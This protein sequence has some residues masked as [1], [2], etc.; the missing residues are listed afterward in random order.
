M[1]AA[2]RLP[3]GVLA[4]LQGTGSYDIR[5]LRL[6]SLT[7]AEFAQALA[8]V[9]D[10]AGLNAAFEVLRSGDGAA[11]NV[12]GTINVANGVATFMPVKFAVPGASAVISAT[13]ELAAG[14]IDMSVT[15]TLSQPF[16]LPP[17]EVSFAGPPEELAR[18]EDKLELIARLGYSLM[19]KGVAELER[20]QRE[21]ERIAAEEERLRRRCRKLAAYYAQRDELLLRRRELKVHAEMRVVAAEK[22]RVELEAERAADLDMNRVEL[23]QRL[24]ELRVHRRV[25]KLASD[26]T[27][28]S[29]TPAARPRPVKRA[30]PP[31]QQ[32]P[33]IIVPPAQ[34]PSQWIRLPAGTARP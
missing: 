6:A 16:G 30:R 33:E 28:A 26:Q 5:D 1:R 9:K 21:Q 23:R 10:A 31:E 15:L 18:A 34:P 19:Q 3:G 22:L 11:R 24:R 12:A 29:E 20:L 8:E 14:L 13:A 7:P 32:L 4:A 17:M 2:G 27:G 25:A